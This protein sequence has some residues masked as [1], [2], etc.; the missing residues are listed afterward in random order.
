VISK[1]HFLKTKGSYVLNNSAIKWEFNKSKT[2]FILCGWLNP[3]SDED[4]QELLRMS[5]K[6]IMLKAIL[7]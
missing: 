6:L 1:F 4:N 2:T 3:N 7:T 5:I